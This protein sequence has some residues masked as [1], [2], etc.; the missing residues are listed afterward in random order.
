MIHVIILSIVISIAIFQ[1]FVKKN[2]NRCSLIFSAIM[3][4]ISII[5][6]GSGTDYFAYLYHYQIS[7]KDLKYVLESGFAEYGYRISMWIAKNL[8]INFEIF[9][10]L[11][12][13]V[14]LSCVYYVIFKN[15]K[16]I[17]LA[18]I[19]FYTGGFYYVYINSGIR[20]GLAMSIFFIGIYKYMISKQDQ[21]KYYITCFI[22][23]L[24]HKSAIITLVI[25]LLWNIVKRKRINL[26]Y[27][28]IIIPVVIM[29]PILGISKI[30][31]SLMSIVG[32]E[33]A[34]APGDSSF[35]AIIL[36]VIMITIICYLYKKVRNKI[37]ESLDS[38]IKVYILMMI[39][40]FVL[41]DF[42]AITRIMEYIGILEVI[43][44][45]SLI[46]YIDEIIE[47]FLT[48]IMILSIMTVICIKDI[49]SFPIQGN[50]YNKSLFNYPLVT[51]FNKEEIY[52][53]RPI[54]VF[55]L[56]VLD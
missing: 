43:I 37:D 39:V 34:Y 23:T 36:R 26:N 16:N 22:A 53:Y 48:G 32:I 6:Y 15:K 40:Y 24:F 10:A 50:Y 28:Y 2:F 7:S 45:P 20:Q 51:V 42:G 38:L 1:L 13:I 46:Y 33:M 27:M 56:D 11:L 9:S 31:Y 3:L 44:I 54:K 25:P 12:A 17:Y 8:G 47:R 5:R 41:S 30:I 52:K 19:I 29:M 49:A 55:I 18:L 14:S 4:I 21:K 35:F